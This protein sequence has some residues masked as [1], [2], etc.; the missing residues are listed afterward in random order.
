MSTHQLDDFPG[1]LPVPNTC[2]ETHPAP[3]RRISF[4]LNPMIP[5]SSDTKA[6]PGR[7]SYITSALYRVFNWAGKRVSMKADVSLSFL[8]NEGSLLLHLTRHLP[9]AVST[10][11]RQRHREQETLEAL[12]SSIPWGHRLDSVHTVSSACTCYVSGQAKRA[13]VISLLKGRGRSD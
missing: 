5:G 7:S 6:N 13:E 8:E 3:T 9:T 10:G 1:E 4:H 2:Q 11:I 12:S